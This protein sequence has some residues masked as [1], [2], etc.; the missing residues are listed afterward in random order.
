MRY[1][2]EFKAIG[3]KTDVNDAQEENVIHCDSSISVILLK[4]EN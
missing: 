2:I 1:S 3:T 4:N